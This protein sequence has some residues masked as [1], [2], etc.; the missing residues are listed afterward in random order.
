MNITYNNQ[1][2]ASDIEKML[3]ECVDYTLDNVFKRIEKQTVYGI[4]HK[5]IAK[6]ILEHGNFQ[7]KLT[8]EQIAFLHHIHETGELKIN[9]M[10]DFFEIILKFLLHASGLMMFY[11]SKLEELDELRELKKKFETK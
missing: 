8:N 6:I 1:I 5:G 9:Q 7:G 2:K 11:T 4:I 3:R 10:N